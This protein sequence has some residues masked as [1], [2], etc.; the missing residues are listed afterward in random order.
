MQ[1]QQWFL[2]RWFLQGLVISLPILI[3][4]IVF[5]YCISY[6]DIILA[7]AANLLPASFPKP[8]FPGM[9]L[10]LVTA[11]LI[12]IGALTETYLI[13]KIVLLFNYIMSKL[14]F[15]RNIYTT[16]LKVVQSFFGGAGK[17]S[18]VVLIEYPFKG[19]YALAFKTGDASAEFNTLTGEPMANIFL[20]TTPN[21]TSGLYLLV[22]IN[23]I[24]ETNLHPEEAFKII[25]SAGI[26]DK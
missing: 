8:I 22:P 13:N 18:K 5:F 11:L 2:K 9:G 10:I 19:S 16:A 1:K 26:V 15:I 4:A 20:P 21:P 3:T 6:T 17:F 7:F 24:K 25:L 14:P 12:I 23:T